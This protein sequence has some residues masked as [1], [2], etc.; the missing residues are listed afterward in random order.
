[1]AVVPYHGQIHPGPEYPLARWGVEGG[2]TGSVQQ[3]DRRSL[4][5]DQRDRKREHLHCQIGH[6]P[7][8]SDQLRAEIRLDRRP[9]QVR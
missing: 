4:P 3:P 6:H 7:L 2:I 5:G 8:I 1:M 9:R